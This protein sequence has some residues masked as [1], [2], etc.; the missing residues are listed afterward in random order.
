MADSNLLPPM[1]SRARTAQ[2][3]NGAAALAPLPPYVPGRAIAPPPLAVEEPA[4]EALTLEPMPVDGVEDA[5]PGSWEAREDVPVIDVEDEIDLE[6]WDTGDNF[7]FEEE[8]PAAAAEASPEAAFPWEMGPAA[9]E[10]EAAVETAPAAAPVAE[11]ATVAEIVAEPEMIELIETTISESRSP[12]DELREAAAESIGAVASEV[13]AAES[14]DEVAGEFARRLEALAERL[15][16]EG[17]R[18]ID[19]TLAE[20]D[21]LD[22]A[23]AGFLTG[24]MASRDR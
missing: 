8:A 20:G 7:A 22:A 17:L 10:P 24:L 16:T 14:I 23:V 9:A 6:G 1:Y 11:A 15:R 3:R 5:L 19:R 4:E 21:R 12:W 2:P 13:G 18:A